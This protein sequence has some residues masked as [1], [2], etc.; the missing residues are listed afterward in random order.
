[1]IRPLEVLF[2][3]WTNLRLR[4][5]ETPYVHSTTLFLLLLTPKISTN[6]IR[7]IAV[8][9][10]SP[11][12]SY[13]DG[14]ETTWQHM[15]NRFYN[16]KTYAPLIWCD[17]LTNKKVF[18]V[19][20]NNNFNESVNE[21]IA[22]NG[23]REDVKILPMWA[24]FSKA[25]FDNGWFTFFSPCVDPDTNSFTTSMLLTSAKNRSEHVS[26]DQF[27]TR[28]DN[29]TR[30]E[31]SASGAY[32]TSQCSLPWASPGKL[33]GWTMQRLFQHILES[34]P[35]DVF[36]SSWNELI[37]GRQKPA[38]TNAVA[39]N[40]GLPKDS[41]RFNVWVDT[42]GTEF[43]RDIEPT[44]EGGDRVYQMMKSCVGMFKRGE[45]CSSSSSSSLELCCD[46]SSTEIWRN[47][48][49]LRNKQQQEDFLVTTDVKERDA[50]VTEMKF[51]EICAVTG[52]ATAFCFNSTDSDG[53]DGPFMLY[54]SAD[55]VEN[56]FGDDE[57]VSPVPLYRCI[58][59][60]S[61]HFISTDLSCEKKGKSESLLGYMSSRRGGETLRELRRCNSGGHSLDL[62][63]VH[64]DGTSMGFVR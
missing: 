57:E 13:S 34:K 42:Y 55:A 32:M 43:S 27:V 2:E 30:S 5:I 11:V 23:G 49:S 36:L 3:E 17:D 46:T 39:F 16:N 25:G 20:A 52:S 64:N 7:Y 48:W 53:R 26:C 47:V 59:P 9:V 15:L 41:Q 19:T 40:M 1:V 8:W 28:F 44:I 31:I 35:E 63:C 6:S 54:N 10:N 21:M 58:S 18:F 38:Y 4:G 56:R 22:S 45:T 14:H 33:R 37:G 50:L 60:L 24:L 12:A 29:D 62:P 51:Q 61:I